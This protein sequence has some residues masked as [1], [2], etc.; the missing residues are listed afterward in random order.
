DETWHGK[1]VIFGLMCWA[2]DAASGEETLRGFRDLARVGGL[3]APIADM[4]QAGPHTQMSPPEAPDYHP[5]AVSLTGFLDRVD[6][7]TAETIMDRLEA[8]GAPAPAVPLPE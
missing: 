2:G 6:R 5:L 7:A 4:L 1:I 3:D 8:P